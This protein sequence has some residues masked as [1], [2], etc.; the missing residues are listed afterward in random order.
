MR[1]ISY[2]VIFAGGLFAT[3]ANAQLFS[4]EL[5][6]VQRRE[7]EG[8]VVGLLRVFDANHRWMQLGSKRDAGMAPEQWARTRAENDANADGKIS[9]ANTPREF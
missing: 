7:V 1:R 2:P 3:A 8:S 9:G 5:R 6:S 4:S